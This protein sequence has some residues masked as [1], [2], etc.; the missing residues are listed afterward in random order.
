MATTEHTGII[1]YLDESGNMK[2]LYPVTKPDAVDGLDE[3]LAGKAPISHASDKN[4]PHGVTI[5][6]I[7]AAPSGYGLGETSN[8]GKWNGDANTSTKQGWH[9]L[10]S[11]T[12]NGV[13]ESASLRVDGYSETDQIQTATTRSCFIKRRVCKSGTWGE[14][15]WVNPPMVLGVEYRTTER[16]NGKA[17]YTML[18]SF[19]ALP[20]STSKIIQT[21]ISNATGLVA[22]SGVF[23]SGTTVGDL[24]SREGVTG[25][26]VDLISSGIRI[27]IVTNT[28]LSMCDNSYIT[29]K[30]V[31][32]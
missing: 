28:D 17:V 13:G 6:Q 24:F 2:L 27:G 30:Y 32:D 19:G 12:A 11:G 14:W 10:E 21:P 20:N 8:I 3:L 25:H 22:L 29:V 5:A 7:G 18:V 4:N 31:K 26:W 16:W 9:R 15:E 1:S 23:G